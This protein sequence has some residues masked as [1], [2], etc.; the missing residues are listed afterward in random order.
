[1]KI[2]R[3]SWDEY[4]MMMADVAKKR[5]DCTRRQVGAIIVRDFRIISTGYNG[6]P[7]KIKNC[8]EG[9]C[10]RCQR[11]DRGEIEGHEYEESCVC[12]HAE[13]NAIIQA[14]L[15]GSS[16]NGSTLYTTANPCSSCAK[17]LAN[18]GIIKVVCRVEHHDLEGIE[19]LKKAGIIVSIVK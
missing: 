10:L 2:K 13:Q 1:M 19:L 11:R 6:T 4:F 9:G 16:T 12:I 7:H 15:H 5:A 14:A 3:P 8:S 18:A 17:I